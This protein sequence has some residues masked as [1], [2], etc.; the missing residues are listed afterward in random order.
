MPKTPSAVEMGAS[1]S[2]TFRRAPGRAAAYSRQPSEPY[3]MSPTATSGVRD[4]TTRP[5]TPPVMT[6]PTS[7]GAA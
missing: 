5:T 6:P 4:S 1:D 3:T 2:S 7:T